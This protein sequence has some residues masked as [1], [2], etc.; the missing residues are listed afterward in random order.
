MQN[1][2]GHMYKNNMHDCF[3]HNKDGT[4]T[5]RSL[6]TDKPRTVTPHSKGSGTEGTNF[7]QII[8][9]EC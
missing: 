4:P 2:L 8:H 1:K 9:E 7:V 6:S 5:K 3:W